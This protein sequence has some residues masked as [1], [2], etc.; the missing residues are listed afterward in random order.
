MALL[1]TAL[2]YC[3]QLCTYI[4]HLLKRWSRYLQKKFTNNNSVSDE[5]DLLGY[6]AKEWKGETEQ[7]KQM[8]KAYKQLFWRHH[9]KYLRQV[10]EDSYCVLR[11]VLFQIFSQGLPVPSWTK[12]VDVLKI[13]EK[14]LYSQGCNWIQQYSFGPEKYTGSNTLG[15][16]R[17][18]IETL[19]SQWMEISGIRDPYERGKLCCAIFTDEDTEH[20][21]F[22]AIKFFMLYQVIEAYECFSN[23]QEGIPRFF[24]SLFTQDTSL[25]PLSYMMNHLNSIGDGRSL[26]QVEL[27][28]LGYVLEVKIIVYKICKFSSDVFQEYC[29]EGYQRDWHEVSLLTEDDRHYHIPVIKM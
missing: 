28:L 17:K 7:A 24:Y 5:V 4:A 20:K 3:R 23:K 22:E 10:K 18:C 9:V 12:A 29:L 26:D 19:K 6:C 13:P 21:M 8:R 1:A 25:D 2:W 27:F 11:A 15:K 14:L 16:L